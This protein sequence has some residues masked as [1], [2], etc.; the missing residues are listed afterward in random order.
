VVLWGGS[1]HPLWPYGVV[2]SIG[3][4]PLGVVRPP[5]GPKPTNIFLVIFGFALGVVEPPPV[6]LGFG[7]PTLNRPL[8]VAKAT[9]MA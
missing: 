1:D 4:G 9:P 3:G 2:E 5:L 8:R 7:L 6:A